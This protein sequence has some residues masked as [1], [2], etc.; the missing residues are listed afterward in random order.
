MPK[1][2]SKNNERY[3]SSDSRSSEI[4]KQ[5]IYKENHM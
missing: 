1:N 5:A 2:V 3:Q 4:L